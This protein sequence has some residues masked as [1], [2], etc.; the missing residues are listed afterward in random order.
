MKRMHIHINVDKLSE[1]IHFYSTIFGIPPS[2]QH[3]DYAK[4]N[5]TDPAVNFAMSKHSQTTGLNHL[6]IEVDSS[7]ELSEIA[8]RF[9]KAKIKF[10]SQKGVACCYTHSNKH[11]TLDPQGIAWESFHSL[12]N[13]PVFGEE[14]NTYSENKSSACCTPLNL[15]ENSHN[16]TPCC[17]PNKG[18]VSCRGSDSI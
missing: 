2:I 13:I 16:A 9:N 6:G 10:S 5:L 7:N 3:E 4:W 15:G 1:N 18:D 11:W 8:Q 12:N 14:T 17:K